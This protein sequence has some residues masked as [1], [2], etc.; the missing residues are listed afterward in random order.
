LVKSQEREPTVGFPKNL[1][2]QVDSSSKK[3]N[4]NV[5]DLLLNPA[6]IS[7]ASAR[8]KENI[9]A[10]QTLFNRL[11]K[12]SSF[13]FLFSTLWYSTMPCFDVKGLTSE[14]QGE[15]SLLKF[16][17]WKGVAV[18][19][20]AI[21]KTFPTER[22]MCCTFNMKA[23]DEIFQGQ[24]YSKT[25][26]AKQEE[27]QMAAFENS[28]IPDWYVKA[29]EPQS[30]AG[31][32]K[33]LLVMLD[34]HYNLLAPVSVDNDFWGFT[35]LIHSKDSFPLM[36]QSG[37][38][39]RTGQNNLIALSATKLDAGA[40]LRQLSP[41]E[42]Q[43]LFSDETNNLV[44]HKHYSQSN[45]FLE[46][47]LLNAQ[48]QLQISYNLTQN[49]TPWYYPFAN[50]FGTICDPWQT[51]TFY[52]LMVKVS[53]QEYCSH[54]LPDCTNTIYRPFITTLP[55]KACDESNFGVSHFCNI[56]DRTLPDPKLWAQLIKDQFINSPN[57]P[58]Y[59]KSIVSNM[60]S[61]N[62]TIF[63][64]ASKKNEYDA[65]EKDIAVVQVF[66]DSP[67]VFKFTSD[68]SMTWVDFFAQ[69]GGILGL[70]IGI[71]LV[72]FIEIFW[73]FVSLFTTTIKK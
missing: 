47:F 70:C 56:E 40:N 16:C 14:K 57:Q 26:K 8:A 22:G 9:T 67:T 30:M 71:S 7:Q 53:P 2:D 18:P 62:G 32:S 33:G 72:T 5:L 48:N 11:N 43:C 10:Y 58:D 27:D 29:E 31:I 13:Q 24:T 6:M 65:Y 37:F 55:F 68:Q 50:D 45:C 46:C 42:R 34:A 23:A 44:I 41:S 15:K 1:W 73:L 51:Q 21:F 28:S 35:G 19:C 54:C 52:E 66:F 49:C 61:A 3:S 38:Q 69:I 25:V 4:A 36:L 20:S 60:R 12:T 39:I 64:S 63:V 59:I 17:Q